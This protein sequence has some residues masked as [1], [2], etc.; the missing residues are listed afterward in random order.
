MVF[1]KDLSSFV[2]IGSISIKWYAVLILIG[3][4]SAF[5]VSTKN[6]QKLGYPSGMIDDLFFGSL[7]SG[8]VGARL[9]Y[10]L[11]YDL[12][13]YIAN[14]ISILMTWQG[15]M[16]I[17][18]GLLLGALFAFF[19]L[20]RK[21]ISFMR[22]A[23]AIVP[24]IL[25]AQAIGRWGNFMNQEAYG[26]IVDEAYFNLFPAFIKNNMLIGGA[27]R[28]PTFLYESVLNIVG[29]ILIVYVLKRFSDNRRG[30]LMYAYL[31]W[32]GVT[33][34]WVEGLRTDSLMFMGFRMAQLTSV[35]FILIGLLGKLG[36]Y[37]RF[38][39]K[40]KPV[41]LFDFDGTL[42]DTEPLIIESMKHTIKQFR[43]EV[44]ISRDDE[45]SF[46]GPTLN[47][48][49]ARYLNESEIEEGI[50]IYRENNK[51]LH[52]QLIKP[53]PNAIEL[54]H[55]LKAE[56]YTIGIVS[57]KKKEMVEYGVQLIGLENQFDVIIGYDEVKQHKPSPEGIFNACKA[58]GI[59][60][61][62]CVYVGDTSTD[63]L[64]SNNAGL[65]S[66]AYLTHPE[67]RDAIMEAK[68]NAT[69]EDLLEIKEILKRNQ[70]WTRSLT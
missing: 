41:L 37:D 53:M 67:R 26:K 65:Y 24:N 36:V 18:G 7:V 49:L 6:L 34:F 10:V 64:A 22:F 54:I 14:P 55:D 25:I 3:A 16:A 51:E 45:I 17:Q 56:G 9:W 44:Q 39:K 43:P 12:Q 27:Y 62:N 4:F 1:F 59:D 66:I 40:K 33:R 11:F 19:F 20:K 38:M 69:V 28:E 15:G 61:D 23:D 5:Y 29:F 57:S 2:D 47:T 58:L 70:T 30:D 63:I 21:G 32:Y 60:H 52:P 42:G 50:K 68:P 35:A 31:M 48:I 46:L 8:I 13:T